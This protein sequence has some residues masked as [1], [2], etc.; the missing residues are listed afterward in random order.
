MSFPG[1]EEETGVGLQH[2]LGFQACVL[3]QGSGHHVL[4]SQL[5]HETPGPTKG[6]LCPSHP[7]DHFTSSQGSESSCFSSAVEMH[8]EV[9]CRLPRIRTPPGPGEAPHKHM[10]GEEK[11]PRL[12]SSSAQSTCPSPSPR[13][14][15]PYRPA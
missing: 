5:P 10:Y 4:R 7:E 3:L 15:T 6:C 8:P 1:Q 9:Q 14:P 11:G 12:V 2:E 13:T